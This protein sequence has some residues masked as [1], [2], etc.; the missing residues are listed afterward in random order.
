MGLG[1]FILRW[2]LKLSFLLLRSLLRISFFLSKR[3]L[4]LHR[5]S[6]GSARWAGWLDLL[7]GGTWGRRDGLIVAKAYGRFI[8]HRSDGAA[9]VYAPMGSGKGVGLVI[10]NLIDHPGALICTDPKGENLAVTGRWRQS[11]GPVYRL[12]ALNPEA[13]HRFNPFDMIRAGTHHEADDIAALADLLITPESSEAH[14]DTSA[15]QLTAMLI[16]HVLHTS[17]PSQRTLS[18]VREL[19]ALG[20]DSFR[21]ELET[22]A[23]GPVPSIAEQARIVLSGLDTEEMASVISNAA[24]ALQFWSRDRIGG[25]LTSASDFD[26]LNI[27]RRT[28]T[29][30]V[31]VPEDKLRVY[32]PFLRLMMGCALAAAVRGKE[33]PPPRH[34]PLLLIDEAAALGRLEALENGLGYLRAYARIL[35]VFQDIGQITRLYGEY[36]ART[37]MAA[38]ACQVAFNVHDNAT[39]RELAEA[40]GMTTALSHS[41]GTSQASTSL[42]HHQLQAGHAESGRYL[43]DPAEIRRMPTDRCLV[44]LTDR[45]KMPI[46]ARKVRYY[47]IRRWRGRWDRWRPN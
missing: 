17:P 28:K 16:G 8:R 36:G 15:R 21:A 34:K 42:L 41:R 29:I 2:M 18:A 1:W 9:L 25:L 12:D 31:V 39:A 3:L 4:A 46:Q 27:H 13:A 44:F 43:L 22:M 40:I 26:F 37:F 24:K 45:V 32:Q 38:S 14:W 23:H 33:L 11:L 47:T 20:G 10:P 30:Y 6:H 19:I 35:L 5:K 7:R